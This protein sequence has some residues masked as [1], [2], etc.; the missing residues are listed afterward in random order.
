MAWFFIISM[1]FPRICPVAAADAPPQV[2]IETLYKALRNREN[3][4]RS[5]EFSWTEAITVSKG[6]FT[7][8]TPHQQ[9]KS[10]DPQPPQN[11]TYDAAYRLVVDGGM[12]RCEGKVLMETPTGGGL[13]DG[14]FIL[15]EGLWKSFR[16]KGPDTPYP[17]G[18]IAPGELYSQTQNTQMAPHLMPLIIVLRPF[19]Y[20][21]I[22]FDRFPT[23]Y[24]V[25]S[26]KQVLRG[27]QCT[28]IREKG[29]RHSGLYNMLWLDNERDYIP[30]RFCRFTDE[31]VSIQIDYFQWASVQS[32]WLPI[33]WKRTLTSGDTVNRSTLAVVQNRSINHAI[34]G[35][36]FTLDFPVDTLV[37]DV[38]NPNKKENYIVREGGQKREISSRELVAAETYEQLLKSEDSQFGGVS[39]LLIFVFVLLILLLSGL[40]FWKNWRKLRFGKK[41]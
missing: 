26:G 14:T 13:I 17:N 20:A 36:E 2:T 41:N 28:V 22:I 38:R 29:E 34:D 6:G 40:Y 25:V 37:S 19:R 30:V 3:R 8:V 33:E 11:T 10:K 15:K 1:L 5:F 18:L 16:P 32:E 9:N 35:N 27:R 23:R 7:E 39:R 12:V 4:I 21:G 31:K 24:S